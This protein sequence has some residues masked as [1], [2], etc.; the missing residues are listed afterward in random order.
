MGTYLNRE[1]LKM[2]TPKE[3]RFVKAKPVWAT[4]REYEMNL[5]LDFKCNLTNAS[6]C[7][8][9]LTGSSAYQ[10]LVNNNFV[11]FGPARCAHGFYRVDN[12]DLSN[13]L[14]QDNNTLVIRVAG[15]NINSFY[16]LNQPSF[17]CC[18][19]I[20]DNVVLFATGDDDND[21]ICEEYLAH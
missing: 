2:Y 18:E 8:L 21:F 14:N 15:Y 12:I 20:K 5:W 3:Y 17:L 11:A 6:N 7:F 16:H 1:V 13:Y 10:I 9:N 4:N 19:V